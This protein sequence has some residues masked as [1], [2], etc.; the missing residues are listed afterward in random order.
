[1]YQV[2]MYYTIKTLL[3]QGKSLRQISKELG[4]CRKTVSRIKTALDSGQ[5]GPA[6]Q[7]RAKVLNEQAASSRCNS[8][9][10]SPLA[11]VFEKK[12]LLLIYHKK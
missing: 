5:V 9:V 8:S 11:I 2:G 12:F 4:V 7:T 3:S 1:M 6:L 10:I